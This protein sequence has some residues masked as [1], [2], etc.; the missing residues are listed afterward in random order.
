MKR[1]I[2][3]VALV[4]AA[5]LMAQP[6]LAN[7]SCPRE[8]SGSD[9]SASNCCMHAGGMP[10]HGV[11]SN[12]AMGPMGQMDSTSAGCQMQWHAALSEPGHGIDSSCASVAVPL[13][14]VAVGSRSMTT[15]VPLLALSGAIG[16]IVLPMRAAR[17]SGVAAAP[18]SAK[19]ILFRDFRI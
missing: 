1:F 8:N 2:Q 18:A 10:S 19:Y 9:C 12:E 16:A 7:A 5:L 4:V 17:L 6:A 14:P 11:S 13:T 3:I 15:G